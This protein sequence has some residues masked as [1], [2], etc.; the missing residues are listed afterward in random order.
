MNPAEW[1][2]EQVPVAEALGRGLQHSHER[3]DVAAIFEPYEKP[4]GRSKSR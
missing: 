1:F 3:F 2:T 4:C